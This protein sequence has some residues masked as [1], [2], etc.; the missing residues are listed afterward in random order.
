MKKCATA[1]LL[2]MLVATLTVGVQNPD[3][4]IKYASPEGRY[5]VSLPAEPKLTSQES[6]NSEGL[7]FTQ[8]MASVGDGNGYYMV[9]YFDLAAGVTYSLDKARDGMLKAVNGTLVSEGPINLEGNPGRELLA[10]VTAADGVDY[11]VSARVYQVD[12]R[13]YILQ[14]LRAKASDDKVAAA[15]AAKFFGSFQIVKS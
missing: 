13:V 10:S 8:Y 4:W 1:I 5:T 15:R 7:K 3:Q 2:L 12:S 9:A 14:F 6:T 11:L